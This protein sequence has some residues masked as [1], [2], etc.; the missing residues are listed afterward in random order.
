MAGIYIHIPFCASK[1][2]YCDFYS[3]PLRDPQLITAYV[4]C[5]IEEWDIRRDELT[6]PVETIY[7]GGGTP[8]LLPVGEIRRL[9]A[10]L[11]TDGCSE[12][13]LEANPEQV[14]S[15]L[16]GRLTSETPVNRISL[17]VQSL[18]D[19][20]L[21]LVG[22]RHTSAQALAALEA[23]ASAPGLRSFSVDLICA[24]PRQTLRSWLAS[25]DGILQF[26]PPH[27]SAYI[28]SYEPGT[29]LDA[30]RRAGKVTPT[31]DD[32]VAS[33]YE[34]LCR[35]L[36]DRG[37]DH[38][39]ISNFALPGHRAI[40][41]SNYWEDRP[42]IGLGAGAHSFAGGSERRSN[43]SDLQLYMAGEDAD[44]YLL[45]HESLTDRINDYI[46]LRL[47]TRSGLST[48]DFRRR[49]GSRRLE[50]LISAATPHLNRGTLRLDPTDSS[51]RFTESSWLVSDPVIAELFAD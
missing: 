13:T 48:A 9:L 36:A 2:A 21:S 37:Y 3:R 7:L 30:M 27:I 26:A 35:R 11:P 50:Q 23:L 15:E 41:N 18:S 1:C 38:Y 24:L 32:T 51:L 4:D 25:I 33:L 22:R 5:L 6:E 20:E 12:I 17:G 8:S 31:D 42:Y 46:M 45:E 39:E 44:R 40:H 34:S 28:L 47:R 29:R 14:D 16:I 43:Y 49:F 10:A 19:D